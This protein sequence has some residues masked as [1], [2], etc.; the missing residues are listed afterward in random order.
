MEAVKTGTRV[1]IWLCGLAA[2][3]Y[4]VYY[5]YTEYNFWAAVGFFF[6]GGLGITWIMFGINKILGLAED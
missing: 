3:I 2:Q 1:V 5:I 4:G 6:M